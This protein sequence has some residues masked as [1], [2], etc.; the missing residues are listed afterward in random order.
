MAKLLKNSK[1]ED[2][3]VKILKIRQDEI[4]S[5]RSLILENY[6]S[7]N[8]ILIE[9]FKI[10]VDLEVFNFTS[11]PSILPKLDAPRGSALEKKYTLSYKSITKPFTKNAAR[12]IYKDEKKAQELTSVMTLCEEYVCNIFRL[13]FS[14]E[15]R[16]DSYGTTW[17]FTNTKK[18]NY[19]FDI[20]SG[21]CFRAFWNLSSNPR[22]WGFGYKIEDV[23][24]RYKDRI[25]SF[26]QKTKEVDFKLTQ[27][28]FNPFLN[29]LIEDCPT[30]IVKYEQYDL[31]L[32]DSVKVAHQIIGGDKLAAFTYIFDDNKMPENVYSG[33]NYV[34][35]ISS[36]IKSI[37]T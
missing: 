10:P 20:Y 9:N 33:L 1:L 36:L 15:G 2:A 3:S 29:S 31:W 27:E 16:P 4:R 24:K 7:G 37:A 8:I 17:R 14:L 32:C 25:N 5:K 19:H 22:S 13:I 26:V 12:V 21:K 6:L 18:Q 23:F 30:H 35:N 11:L 34:D 28:N